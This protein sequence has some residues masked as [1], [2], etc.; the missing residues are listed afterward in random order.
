MTWTYL[1]DTVEEG[2]T[3][4]TLMNGV[5]WKSGS[6]IVIAT[7]GD[8]AS[9]GESEVAVIDSVS[10]DG[11]EIT[12]AAPLKFRHISISQTFGSH[13]VETRAEVGL[14]TR[15]IKVQGNINEQFVT[16]IPACEKPFVANEEAVQSCFQGKFG[17]EIGTDEFGAIIFIHAA[18]I[19]KHLAIARISYSEFTF[20]GQAFRVGRYPIHFHINGNATSSYVRGNAI[21]R[22]FNRACT[23]HAV[24]NLVV[25]HNVAF[26]VKGLTFFIEDGVEEDN[27]IQYNLA[28][29]TRQ[30]NSLLNPDIQ[31]GSFWVVNPNN[32]IQHNAVAGSTHFGFWYR[33]LQ[34]P[35]GPSR[36][37]SYCPAGAPMGR[38]YN[39]SAHSCGLYGIWIFTAGEPGW[40]PK[41]G[42][43]E[44]GYC[45]GNPITATFGDFTAWNNEIGVEV[46]ESGAIRFENMT[47]LDNEKSGVELIHPIGVSRQNG[48]EYGA[49]TFKN[50]VVIGH[51]DVTADW[52][53]GDTFCTETGV[54]SGWWGNDV[55]NVEFY[56][57][58]RT[59]CTA[60]GSC[61]RCKPK[62]AAGKTQTSGL[63]FT[64]SPNKVSWPWT[65]SGHYHDLDGTLC[66][67]P[68]CKVVQKRDIY[69]PSKCVDDTDDEFSHI[70][71]GSEGAD[72]LAVGLREND[73]I[74]LDAYVCDPDMKFHSVGFNNYAPTSLMYNDVVW[75]NEFGA[76][77]T[78]W[79]KKPPY[80]NGW[81]AVLPEATTNFFFWE[82]LGHIT[83]ITYEMGIFQLADDGDYLL[84]GHNF[85]QSPDI[86]TFNGEAANET[87]ALSEPPTYETAGNT[88]W[89]WS[90]NDTRELTYIISHKNKGARRKRGSKPSEFSRSITFRVYRC[91]YE[92]CLP[93][94]P[95]TVPSGRP[96]DFLS[97]SSEDDWASLDLTKP[98]AG[99][100]GI[101]PGLITIP[102]GVWMVLDE[103]PPPLTR[104]EYHC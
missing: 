68:D 37:S 62:W 29:F 88:D 66:G 48:E 19:N 53:N 101:V 32:I 67:T 47:L 82:T 72:W 17:E 3:T 86:F 15:N 83:N 78:P 69:D 46:V 74:K 61:A 95:P 77:F 104:S 57:F 18:E 30:S 87:S 96:L 41:D 89:Y 70:E 14:L 63:S 98:A 21:H 43:R 56:N 75:H 28:V 8:R 13:E 91:L 76:A 1:A 7:T 60:L 16:E 73:T 100:D 2:D 58:D 33:V 22:S 49:P 23:I 99:P 5:N 26:N 51:S 34:N 24:N 42:T 65:M 12:L 31:P 52:P 84:M 55:E 97:W 11:T 102:P 9:M 40:R 85:T 38:F 27:I 81:A 103:I 79:R 20:V 92:G 64:N 54:K 35:D 25:E 93:P 6:E 80:A 90:G 45:H 10:A 50:S 94:P 71:G 39:N 36:T 4:I 44:N 59:A